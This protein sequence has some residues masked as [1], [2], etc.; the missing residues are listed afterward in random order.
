MKLTSVFLLVAALQVSAS[1]YG[2]TLTLSL[3]NVPLEKAI[4]EIE[5]QS[6]F[7]FLYT[8]QQ[9]KKTVPV[10]IEVSA[11]PL[12]YVLAVCFRGQP[13]TYTIVRNTVIVK[14]AKEAAAPAAPPG[15][16]SPGNEPPALVS[17]RVIARDGTPLPG[18]TVINRTTRQ[19]T[20][21][22]KAGTFSIH[23][24]DG[25]IIS[26]SFIGY[27]GVTMR[28]HTKEGITTSLIPAGAQPAAASPDAAPS[29]V[30][31]GSAGALV[32]T[33]AP[34]IS[35]LAGVTV[36]TGYQTIA[37]ERSAGAFAKPSMDIIAD[38][39]GS[40]NVIQRLDGLVPGLTMNNAPYSQ[41]P[42]VIR[43]LSTIGLS[44]QQSVTTYTGTSRSPLFVVD[45]IPMS[46]VSSVNPQ[47]VEDITVLKDATAASIWGANASNG[48]VVIVTKKG[49]ANE[50]MKVQYD[51]FINFQG[52]PDLDYLPVLN[53]ADYIRTSKEIFDPVAFPWAA[54][55]AYSSSGTGV[56]PHMMILYNR[57]RGLISEEAANKSLDSLAGIDNGR[58]IEDLWY[59]NASLMNHTISLSGGGKVYSYYGS[60]AYTSNRSPVP[61][62][63]NNVFKSNIRQDFDLHK[64]LKVYLITDF[65]NTVSSAQRRPVVD[66]RFYPY[67]LFRDENGKNLS[68][69]YVGDA[70]DSSRLDFQ[71][72]SRISLDYNPLDETDYG[73]SKTEML[74]SRI[75]GGLTLHLPGGLRLEGVYGYIKGNGTTAIY[76]DVKSY[77]VR[78][79]IV[80]FTV[81]P[82]T[83]STPVY[84]MP[85]TGGKYAVS[86]TSQRNWTVR[87]QLVYDRNWGGLRHQLTL[88]AGQEAQDYLTNRKNTVARGYDR[89][90]LT[91]RPVDF[92]TLT[93][94]G[95]RP[96]VMYTSS[97][98][99][100]R[101]GRDDSYSETE[102]QTR[103]VSY[104]AN[105]AYTF[106]RKYSVN[107]SWRIDRSNL[108]GLDKSAQNR[109]VWSA[110]LKWNVSGETFMENINTIGRLA[111]RATYGISGN[112][113][114]AGTASSYDILSPSTSVQYPDGLSYRINSPANSK[115]TWESTRMFNLGI[116]FSI[117]NGRLS[118]SADFYRKQ[119]NDL[120]GNMPVNGFSGYATIIGNFGSMLNRGAE[121]A[122]TSRNVTSGDFSW[123]SMVNI[124]YNKNTVTQLN[125]PTALTTAAQKVTAQYVTGFPAFSI[126]AY[127]Y[128]GVD[129]LGD[130]LIELGDKTVTKQRNAAGLDD[131]V[132]MGTYQPVW[133]GGVT[134][135]FH[136]RN[137]TLTANA[138]LNLG[139]V[140]RRD[141][142]HSYFFT[143]PYSGMVRHG[144]VVSTNFNT[145]FTGGQF[146]PIFLERWKQ[147]GD[148]AHTDVPSYVPN[149]AVNNSRRDVNY[150]LYADRN[151]LSA[152]YI[153]MRD[154][155]LSYALP[156]SILSRIAAERIV[157][158]A[159][160]SNIML[161]KANRYD[162]DPEFHEASIGQR[163][164]AVFASV[165][166]SITVQGY[167]FGQGTFTVGLHVNF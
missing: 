65:T 44:S 92:V 48:V 127:R 130:P 119:T 86:T 162:I 64:R 115:L 52:K 164:P 33:L 152:S 81:A 38:R 70:S 110:G 3:K 31:A 94:T 42:F 46:D 135:T 158:R 97:G 51:G 5:R 6:G 8:E 161:W 122:L 121:I 163:V 11:R 1:S 106:H 23:A 14:P 105:M 108:F 156:R 72:R 83:A 57:S 87:N 98:N 91:S 28:V 12:Q 75:T 39:S 17:G 71:A 90:L 150:F 19:S 88:L 84:Y 27:A 101:L 126:F 16:E 102:S 67:Q 4:Q 132:F 146:H 137:F 29:T 24:N 41:N 76:D 61:G 147:P 159:Q 13:L 116:D 15:T 151:V 82:T 140:M 58:Q 74:L 78:R 136:Y 155:T 18:A 60:L 154:I 143:T 69:P 7:R 153:K 134:N 167:R 124:A 107:G 133:S 26:V 111:V 93:G 56:A 89:S 99:T 113:P 104:Y 62:E 160:V 157:V 35:Q 66:K 21:T 120:L 22:D 59:R 43:G 103:I 40:T 128:R 125:D 117:L 2:Q 9:L 144:N 55:S 138:V 10:T 50:K 149:A 141:V 68:I 49:K 139:H 100:T 112:P 20:G 166:P 37:K 129:N 165:D 118:G 77:R 34:G 36:S 148:E 25:D 79:E 95:V 73:D 30:V 96:T 145:G 45:G 85:V 63:K 54:T 123:S 32:I 109:P 142:R 131:I 114:S 47:D 80:Q 53:S